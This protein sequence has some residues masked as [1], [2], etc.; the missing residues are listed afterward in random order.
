MGLISWVKKNLK[1]AVFTSI[2][3]RWG[4]Q[5]INRGLLYK[6]KI[7]IVGKNNVIEIKDGAK[8][9]GCKIVVNG[10][11]NCITIGAK[12]YLEQCGI[13]MDFDGNCLSIG[14]RCI[15]SSRN[16][17]SICE[18]KTISF[19]NDCLTSA[20]IHCRTT[21][22]HTILNRNGERINFARDI[23]VGNHV[24]IGANVTLLKGAGIGNNCVVSYGSIVTRRIEEDNCVIAGIPAKVVK[25]GIDWDKKLYREES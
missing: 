4:N 6:C 19:G 3:G 23:I 18:G 25:Q 11:N 15:F 16:H 10:S 5:I 1:I 17:F 9:F 22:S 24:W 12:S 2:R 7:K 13:C 21:D 20:D 8:L 14:E